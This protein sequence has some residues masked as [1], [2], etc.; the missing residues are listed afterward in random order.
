[1]RRKFCALATLLLILIPASCS[2]ASLEFLGEDLMDGYVGEA[3]SDFLVVDG[4]R[5][6]ITWSGG[7]GLPPGL[8]M[9]GNGDT[10][11]ITGTP[12]KE[13]YYTFTIRA[14]DSIVGSAVAY[15]SIIID[16][17]SVS[18]TSSFSTGIKNLI[19]HVITVPNQRMHCISARFN[20]G[21]EFS[22]VLRE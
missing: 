18:I 12:T 3:Y 11:Y 10:V 20:Y 15:C 1:M 7:G 9:S 2:W 8:S 13:G 19:Y 4:K 6:T 16:K 17:L 14:T 22:A 21:I 5:G